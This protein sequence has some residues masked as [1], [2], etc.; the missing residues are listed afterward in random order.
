[1]KDATTRASTEST[2][3]RIVE[4]ATRLFHKNGYQSTSLEEVGSELGVT[5]QAFYYYYKSKEDLLWDI[6]STAESHLLK[7]CEDVL[8]EVLP[9]LERLAALVRSYADIMVEHAPEV[10]CFFQEERAL[11]EERKLDLRQTRREF[12]KHFIDAYAEAM[13]L[14]FVEERDPRLAAFLLLGAC[15]WITWWY[16]PT[17]PYEPSL[18]AGTVT[19]INL[20]G[21]LTDSG[22][23]ALRGFGNESGS[24]FPDRG[25]TLT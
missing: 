10:A 20:R 21:V 1:M 14:G 17:G 9:P 7:A 24:E 8:Q 18:V 23:E 19:E 5:R 16:S 15:N 22:R 3:D 2:K 6:N 13:D 25:M 12:T 4:T 11:S